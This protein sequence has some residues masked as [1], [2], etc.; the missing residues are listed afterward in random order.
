MATISGTINPNNAY[1]ITL[2][3]TESNISTA[4]NTSDVTV[5]GVLSLANQYYSATMPSG[6]G[7]VTIG[8]T[9]YN[10]S[11]DV[12]INSSHTSAQLFS[13]TVTGIRHNDSDGSLN[14]FVSTSFNG[15]TGG[16]YNP[17]G[18]VSGTVA[19]TAIPRG[20]IPSVNPSEVVVN[21]TN[22]VT[23][24][25]NRR[26][27]GYTHTLTATVG[28][29][30]YPIATNVGASAVWTVPTA[31]ISQFASTSST[32]VCTITCI[33]YTEDNSVLGTAT[34][35]L[36]LKLDSS[37]ASPTVSIVSITEANDA[38]YPGGTLDV[39]EGSHWIEGYSQPLVTVSATGAYGASIASVTINNGTATYTGVI[40]PLTGYYSYAMDET[41][42]GA[43][44]VT[45]TDSRGLTATVTQT[46]TVDSYRG[47]TISN[48]DVLRPNPN[49]NTA[50]VTLGGAY[51]QNLGDDGNEITTSWSYTPKGGTT[52]IAGAF[53]FTETSASYNSEWTTTVLDKDTVYTLSFTVSDKLTS[54]TVSVLAYKST[55]V[56]LFGSNGKNGQDN[57][58]DIFGDLVLRDESDPAAN[59]SVL[60]YNWIDTVYP[61][62]SVYMTVLSQSQFDPA[63]AWGGT[64]SLIDPGYYLMSGGTGYLPIA[65]SSTY[66]NGK[67]GGHLA[68]PSG[69][70]ATP[71]GLTTG[72]SSG[73]ANRVAVFGSQYSGADEYRPPWLAV[74]VW[75]RTA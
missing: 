6:S 74:Y 16:A 68:Y 57:H 60:N 10:Y 35:S 53:T 22:S 72:A 14:L 43:I 58:F 20:S 9:T 2:T 36:T 38:I 49:A 47:I 71:Y 65:P 37:V 52:V 12:Y 51:T 28:S 27:T 25:T 46:I 26:S 15:G 55:P 44:T 29:T 3:V 32:A 59:Y 7:S 56:F 34:C 41:G 13:K 54:A 63:V 40:D 42:T 70:E 21:G 24:N 75:I 18:T 23:I 69:N 31:V 64:W 62:G 61:V 67:T 11:A 33:T 66:P 17:N 5:V 19:L 73:F 45:A 48:V 30:E 4:N 1:R 50:R 8:S 39:I